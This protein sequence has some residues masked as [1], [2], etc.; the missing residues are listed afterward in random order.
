MC[1]LRLGPKEHLKVT[2]ACLTQPG[3]SGRPTP[4]SLDTG[5]GFSNYP[6]PEG[7]TPPQ[8]CTEL[9][10]DTCGHRREGIECLI[11][12]ASGNKPF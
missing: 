1:F 6:S 12:A 5:G 4:T 7:Q 2:R 3:A 8:F 10:P 9:H 11:L